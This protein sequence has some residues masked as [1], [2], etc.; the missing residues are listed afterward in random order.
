MSH[1]VNLN[2]IEEEFYNV[3]GQHQEI[4]N[5]YSTRSTNPNL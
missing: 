1:H 3:Q 4:K 2:K 5:E